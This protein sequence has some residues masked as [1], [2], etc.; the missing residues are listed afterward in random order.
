MDA[1]KGYDIELL[2]PLSPGYKCPYC[3][4]VMRDPIQTLEGERACRLCY[5]SLGLVFTFF[6]AIF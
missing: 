2:K 5:L 6:I 3:E 4:F 1:Q